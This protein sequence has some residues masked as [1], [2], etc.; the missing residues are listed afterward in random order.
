MRSRLKTFDIS[1]AALAPLVAIVRNDL[2]PLVS[3]R[4]GDECDH[5]LGIAHVEDFMRHAGLDVDEIAGLVFDCLFEAFTELVSHLS[6]NDIED[7]FEADMDVCIRDA[8][9]RNGSDI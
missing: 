1:R 6:F 9:R 5:R 2:V 4:A 7:Y 8:A 3:G